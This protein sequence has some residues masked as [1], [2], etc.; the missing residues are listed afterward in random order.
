[1]KII[2]AGS[3]EYAVPALDR[4]V[5]S[6]RDVV[7]VI[8]QPDKPAGRKKIMTP[9]PVKAYAVAHG[10]PVIDLP[11]IRTHVQEVAAFAAD[12]MI[13]CAYGQILSKELLDLFPSGV[14]NL[15][16]SLLPKL[17]G[18]SPIQSAI[19]EG[20]EYTGVTVMKTEEGLDTGDILLV[21]RIR[22][23]NETCGELSQKLSLLSADA[24]TEALEYIES[25]D[26][27]LL[28]QNEY[29]A[30]YCKKVSKEDARLDFTLPAAEIIR[31]VKAYSPDPCAYCALNGTGLNI[32]NA[33]LCP[34]ESSAGAD[35]PDGTYKPGEVVRADK[36]GIIVACGQGMICLTVLQQAGGKAMKAADFVNGRKIKAGDI[37]E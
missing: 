37:L 18:A 20:F 8:T 21:K 24:V 7:A 35:E 32:L 27:Q 31:R 28:I 34:A 29:S 16:A 23:G 33:D 17:R 30:T 11:R 6:G 10:I 2:F 1:M 5:Q 36:K 4:I 22:I 13:T 14:W 12:L 15:H 26:T 19:L 25:G 9:T 3:P